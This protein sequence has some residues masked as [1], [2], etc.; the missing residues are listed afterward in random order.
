MGKL[1]LYHYWRS[2]S[3]WRVRWGFAMKGIDCE[4]VA[5][6][7]LNGESESPEHLARNPL[8]YVPVLELP[9]PRGPMYL[10]ESMAILEWAE[11]THPDPSLLPGDALNRARIR[12]LA[13]V[14]SADTQPLQ[15]LGPQYL[16]SEDPERRKAW[17]QHWIRHGMQ[18]YEK[19]VDETAG[20]FSV[21]DTV[22]LADLCL[23]PQCYNALR[24]EVALEEFPTIHRIYSAAIETP[25]YFASAPERFEPRAV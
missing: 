19:M 14:I 16:H 12:Q 13:E 5:V 10:R 18:A 20:R 9:G 24:Y 17:A 11:E 8:G 7:L 6:N 3:S 25:G 4:L 22:S 15:N 23:V 21:G 1:K 2:S